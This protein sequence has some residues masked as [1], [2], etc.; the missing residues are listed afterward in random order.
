M[1]S[2]LRRARIRWAIESLDADRRQWELAYI[3]MINILGQER[4][5]SIFVNATDELCRD[6]QFTAWE[7]AKK[8]TQLQRGDKNMMYPLWGVLMVLMYEDECEKYLRMS[9]D[10]LCLWCTLSDKTHVLLLIPMML[11][12]QAVLGEKNE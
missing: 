9:I 8:E 10:E 11:I 1:S 4:Y 12:K 3:S 6:F 5:D 7:L 2:T